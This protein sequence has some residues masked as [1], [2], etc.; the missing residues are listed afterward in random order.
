MSGTDKVAQKFS[1][2]YHNKTWD[3]KVLSGPGSRPDRNRKYLRLVQRMV[4]SGRYQSVLDIGCGDW[5]LG[6]CIDWSSVRYCGVDVVSHVVEGNQN[7]F[8]RENVEFSCLNLIDDD[9]PPADLVII[10]DVLQHLPTPAVSVALEK[11]SAYRAVLAVN[12]CVRESRYFRFRVVPRWFA[13][14]PAP[15]IEIEPGDYRPVALN[16]P[17]FLWGARQLFRYAVYYVRGSR[18]VK[19]VLLKTTSDAA[20]P[21]GG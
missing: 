13:V 10:K 18:D 19:E 9:L 2:I 12:D 14:D 1:A 4:N 7:R 17:P 3:E 5:S 6:R 21:L 11:L 16:E 15:N 20:N 8:G